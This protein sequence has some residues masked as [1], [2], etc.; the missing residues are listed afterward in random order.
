MG[1]VAATPRKDVS[2]LKRYLLLFAL[3]VGVTLAFSPAASAQAGHF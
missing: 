1:T 2:Q 3:A